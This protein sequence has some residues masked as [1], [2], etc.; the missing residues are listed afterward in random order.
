MC[1]AQQIQ[2]VLLNIMS[3]ARYALNKRYPEPNPEKR[4]T[5]EGRHVNQNE[6]PYI[7]LT[8]TDQGTGIEHDIMDR[9]FDPFFSTKPSGEGTGLGLSISHGLVHENKGFL[10]VS[11]EFGQSTSLI[12]DLPVAEHTGDTHDN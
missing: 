12:I 1:N 3:N 7:R 5:I 2:Q 11:S 9:L 8:V 6:K 4:I 10:R